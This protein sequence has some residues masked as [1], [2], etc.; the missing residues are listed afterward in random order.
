MLYSRIKHLEFRF[1]KHMLG[2]TFFRKREHLLDLDRVPGVI[3]FRT[4][5]TDHLP[6]RWFYYLDFFSIRYCLPSHTRHPMTVITQLW[7]AVARKWMLKYQHIVHITLSIQ[8]IVMP[9]TMTL[10]QNRLILFYN[11]FPGNNR[12][13]PLRSLFILT[14]CLDLTWENIAFGSVAWKRVLT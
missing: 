7:K 12:K 11:S 9:V 4:F 5:D 6:V 2:F 1:K 14:I 8:C 13:S 3:V 10:Q